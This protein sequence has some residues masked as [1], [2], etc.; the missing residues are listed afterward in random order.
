MLDLELCYQILHDVG[1]G[2][3]CKSLIH[4]YFVSLQEWCRDMYKEMKDDQDKAYFYF[5]D[6]LVRYQL[7][8]KDSFNE[9]ENNIYHV[10]IAK[11]ICKEGDRFQQ[12][13]FVIY[14]YLN[15][16]IS[17]LQDY[18]KQ[19]TPSSIIENPPLP[20]PIPSKIRGFRIKN[21]DC[22]KNRSK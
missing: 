16:A 13:A 5:R 17:C 15:L 22:W 8:K 7:S 1:D 10:L 9:K 20:P 4:P 11:P 21:R 2:N 18:V 3:S 6:I 14:E 19:L 12:M